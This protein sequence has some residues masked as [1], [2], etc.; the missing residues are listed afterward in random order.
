MGYVLGPLFLYIHKKIIGRKS[1][2]G[3]QQRAKI[4]V[5]KGTFKAFFPTLL[6]FSLSLWLL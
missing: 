2:Y 5:F 3:I 4:N 1:I 6:S